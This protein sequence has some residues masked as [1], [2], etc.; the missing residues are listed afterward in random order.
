MTIRD[1]IV[2]GGDDKVFQQGLLNEEKLTSKTAKEIITPWQ[3]ADNNTALCSRENS[4]D[5]IVTLKMTCANAIGT[6]M[7][8]L[9]RTYELASQGENPRGSVKNHLGYTQ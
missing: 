1:R 9:G 6:Y 4:S 8:T 5:Q 2:A 3:F 7:R